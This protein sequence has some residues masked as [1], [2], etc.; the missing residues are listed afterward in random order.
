V[1]DTFRFYSYSL[2]DTQK[3]EYSEIFASLP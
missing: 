1:S 3:V 2:D